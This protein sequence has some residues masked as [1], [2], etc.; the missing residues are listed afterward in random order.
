M[1]TEKVNEE[2]RFKIY[3][4]KSQIL[5]GKQIYDIIQ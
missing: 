2:Y 3:N 5:L 1:F 4:E